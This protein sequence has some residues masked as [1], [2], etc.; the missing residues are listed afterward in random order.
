M[1]IGQACEQ[2]PLRLGFV[3]PPGKQPAICRPTNESDS[4]SEQ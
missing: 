2:Q 1:L 3:L 4:F